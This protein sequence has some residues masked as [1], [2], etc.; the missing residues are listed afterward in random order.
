MYVPANALDHKFNYI[1]KHEKVKRHFTH[2]LVNSHINSKLQNTKV[3]ILHNHNISDAI[4]VPE[5]EKNKSIDLTFNGT[6]FFA[7]I[8]DS[9]NSLVYSVVFRT[10][11][12]INLNS[13]LFRTNS[14]LIYSTK[15]FHYKTNDR[16]KTQQ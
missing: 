9:Q 4:V 16:L 2:F 10:Y 8:V 12:P 14:I 15:A 6:S 7:K 13:Q 1:K 11:H 5:F 3:E